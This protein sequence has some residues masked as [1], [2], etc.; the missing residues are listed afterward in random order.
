MKWDRIYDRILA[1]FERKPSSGRYIPEIDG[2]RFVAIVLVVLFHSHLFFRDGSE[3]VDATQLW[4]K[5]WQTIWTHIP[6]FFIAKGWFGVQIFF[7]IS[8]MVLALPF[9]SHYLEGNRKPELKQYFKRR[10]VR[11]ELPYL[12]TLTFFFATAIIWHRQSLGDTLPPYLSG[13]IYS[14]TLLNDGSLNPLLSVSWTLEI[15]VQFYLMA[16]FLCRIFKVKQVLFRRGILLAGVLLAEVVTEGLHSWHPS[17]IWG[18]SLIGQLGY[19]LIGILLA[20]IFL[21]PSFERLKGYAGAWD[22]VGL[23]IWPVTFLLIEWHTP[24]NLK[25]FALL[26]GFLAVLCGGRLLKLFRVRW[27]TAIGAMCYTIYL[28]HNLMLYGVLRPFFF[29]S[30]IPVT[31]GNWPMNAFLI[32]VMAA[33]AIILCAALFLIVE[34]PF[35]RGR[36]PWRKNG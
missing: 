4:E 15:E 24:V 28:F 34:K 29:G 25:P 12:I 9:A 6:N 1:P 11:I 26:F 2:L 22:C 10:L 16:P 32:V 5:D 3:P 7:V 13:L 35:A 8:G 33:M 27:I 23:L 36:L 14:Y 30:V 31:P 19:F 18:H 17:L 20:D 21:S